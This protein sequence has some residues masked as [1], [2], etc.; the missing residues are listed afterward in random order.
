MSISIITDGTV[1]FPNPVFEG[2]NLVTVLPT[3]WAGMMPSED[4][5]EIK[6][7]DLPKSL[8]NNNGPSL[9][10][11]SKDTYQEYYER[12][13]PQSEGILT[14]ANSS[15]INS[16]YANALEAA[17]EMQGKVPIRVVDS[18]NISLALG[19]IVQRA[20]E[21]ATQEINLI[22]LELIVRNL[23]PRIYSVLCI[24]SLSYLV[25]RGMVNSTQSIIGEHLGMLPVFTMDRGEL[26]HSE[27]ARNNRHLVDILHE[28]LTEFG[29][30]EHISLLQGIPTFETETR[31]LRERLAEDHADTPISEQ[32]IGP[33]IASIIGPH[34]LGV[35]ALQSA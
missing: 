22:E 17:E 15:Y 32:N 1:Q 14:L 7:T 11:Y 6:A 9:E 13:G 8:I 19:M 23:I 26:V 20:A 35:F 16:N 30:L 18:Q 28:F 2:R 21:R 25:R 4:A 34:S 27:K 33:Q 5:Q 24:P 10:A 3:Q 12:L 29:E 31:A